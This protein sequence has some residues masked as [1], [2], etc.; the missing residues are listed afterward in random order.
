MECFLLYNFVSVGVMMLLSGW[1]L[2]NSNSM[3]N[4]HKMIQIKNK[5][6]A[7]GNCCEF[8]SNNNFEKWDT[9]KIFSAHNYKLR[10]KPL[11]KA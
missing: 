9:L 11:Q 3:Q 5:K 7:V 10:N 4:K 8:C 1:H 6:P 2:D